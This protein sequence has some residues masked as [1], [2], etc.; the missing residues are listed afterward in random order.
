MRLCA[1]CTACSA[2]VSACCED[3]S[4]SRSRSRT[5]SRWPTSGACNSLRGAADVARISS[6]SSR[7]RAS[8]ASMS[9]NC[10]SA[11]SRLSRP[12]VPVSSLR[13][14]SWYSVRARSSRTRASDSS[15]R[16]AS[17]SRSRCW[18]SCTRPAAIPTTPPVASAAR[19]MR[20]RPNWCTRPRHRRSQPRFTAKRGLDLPLEVRA[21]LGRWLVWFDVGIHRLTPCIFMMASSSRR[22]F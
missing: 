10:R 1:C 3:S 12:A 14:A 4:S 11:A 2:A 22:S 8:D 5:K 15:E 13:C 6:M 19:M 16:A 21:E 7:M 20:T 9:R 17:T 18:A